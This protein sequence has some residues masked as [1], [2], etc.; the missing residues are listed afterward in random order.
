VSSTVEEWDVDARLG[1]L[2]ECEDNEIEIPPVA[3]MC[4]QNFCNQAVASLPTLGV[5][6]NHGARK[7]EKMKNPC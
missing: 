7:L 6:Q 1:I 2:Q 5:L 4:V 3:R